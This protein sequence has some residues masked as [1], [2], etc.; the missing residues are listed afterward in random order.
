MQEKRGKGIIP[1]RLVSF[2]PIAGV[3]VR[4]FCAKGATLASVPRLARVTPG[5]EA[6]GTGLHLFAPS[7]PHRN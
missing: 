2:Q 5:V 3:I 7:L 1:A 4:A 6:P